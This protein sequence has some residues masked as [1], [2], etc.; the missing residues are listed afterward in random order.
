MSKLTLPGSVHF[1]VHF[2]VQSTS[3]FTSCF[4]PLPG[5]LPV[6]VWRFIPFKPSLD[7]VGQPLLRVYL[8]VPHVVQNSQ[9]PLLLLVQRRGLSFSVLHHRLK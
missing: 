5:S 7:A 6:P 4:R 2:L 9:Q 8:V 1:L 3:W